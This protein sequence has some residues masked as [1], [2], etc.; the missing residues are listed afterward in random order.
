MAI[1]LAQ[2]YRPTKKEVDRLKQIE[3][4]DDNGKIEII[5]HCENPEPLTEQ[6]MA[7]F[8]Y[9]LDDPECQYKPK[10]ARYKAGIKLKDFKRWKRIHPTFL[11]EYK[12][13]VSNVLGE[14]FIDNDQRIMSAAEGETE[15]TDTQRWAA[16]ALLKLREDVRQAEARLIQNINHINIK[17]NI[18]IAMS[19]EE[20]EKYA[21][22]AESEADNG[23][24]ALEAGSGII[25]GQAG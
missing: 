21:G 2:H 23:R 9:L 19:I 22:D 5:D 15:L 16:N 8:A 25:E 13:R 1:D 17:G 6:Q 11:T 14:A 20:L 12:N 4:V 7:F 3:L 24:T 18:N 10:L